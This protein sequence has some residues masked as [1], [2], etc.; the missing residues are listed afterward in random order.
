MK[1]CFTGR[2]GFT[3]IE[4]LVVVLIIGILAAVAVPQYQKAVEKS[5]AMQVLM[6]GKYL[7]DLERNYRL[8]NGEYTEYFDK[9]GAE[10][11]HAKLNQTNTKLTVKEFSITLLRN[12]DR[13][14]IWH[15][16]SPRYNISF[17]L[18]DSEISCTA[19]EVDEYKAASICK[20]LTGD[21]S[22]G[23][24]QCGGTCRYWLW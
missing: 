18:D 19:Y 10:I 1:R 3:L 9:L 13:V 21:F 14:L 23:K 6:I 7:R 16:D 12:Y 22:E 4:L 24:E 8:E 17:N 20:Q 15:Y 2:L 5:R 11:P